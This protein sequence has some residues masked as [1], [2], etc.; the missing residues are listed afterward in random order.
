MRGALLP[1]NPYTGLI[2]SLFN[3]AISV[4]VTISLQRQ[5]KGWQMDDEFEMI[6]KEEIVV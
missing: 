2:C 5:K 1:S 3:D 6:W 4:I